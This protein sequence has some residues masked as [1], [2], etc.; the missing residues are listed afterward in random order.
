[1]QY[2]ARE[3]E[4]KTGQINGYVVSILISFRCATFGWPK[5]A[6]KKLMFFHKNVIFRANFSENQFVSERILKHVFLDLFNASTIKQ[7]IVLAVAN[8]SFASK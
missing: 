8:S 3:R 4:S 1:M 7:L 6:N 5:K 2:N